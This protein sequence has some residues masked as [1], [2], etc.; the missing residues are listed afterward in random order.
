MAAQINAPP[1]GFE[2]EEQAR[3]YDEWFR[4]KVREALTSGKPL[5][6]H[7]EAMARVT[8]KLIE[9]RNARARPSLD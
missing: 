5:V 4:G 2:S 3:R 8:A 1:A 7:D 6:P 9:K